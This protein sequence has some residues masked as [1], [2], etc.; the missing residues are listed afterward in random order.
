MKKVLK[1]S[2]IG[3]STFIVIGMIAVVG[4][5][6]YIIGGSDSGTPTFVEYHDA[7]DY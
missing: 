1:Y 3:C 4:V 2:L 7:E 6:I 5:T